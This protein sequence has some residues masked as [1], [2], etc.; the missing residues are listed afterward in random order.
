MTS[1]RRSRWRALWILP[2]VALGIAA[3]VFMASGRQPPARSETV[4]TAYP[5]RTI[6]VESVEL[7]PQASGY[8]EVQPAKV[9]AAVAQVAGRV[10]ETHA[11]L[12]N[13]EIVPA[14]TLLF[15][16]DPV[17]YELQ[18]AQA[19]AELAE[20]DVQETN[21]RASLAI[22]QRNLRLAEREQARLDKLRSNGTASQ[23]DVDT[24]ERATLNARTS[25]Q[26]TENTLA[27]LPT[28]RRLLEA[29]VAQAERDLANTAVAAPFN[30]RVADLAVERDQYVGVGQTLFKGD[31]V[32]SVEIVAQV[33]MTSLRNLFIGRDRET[34]SLDDLQSHLADFTGFRPLVRMNLGG[35]TAEWEAGFVR[36][37]DQVDPRTRSIGVVV[38]V[39][40]PLG[41]V[42]PGRRPPL[43]KG[44]F[45]DVVIRGRPQPDRVVLPRSALRNGAVYLVDENQRLQTRPL[46]LLFNQ[47]DLSVVADGLRAGDRLVVTDPVPAVAG[48][49]L[50]P[51]DDEALQTWLGDALRKLQ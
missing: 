15:R 16:I 5:V 12:R 34:L 1:T 37:S 42:I 3:I 46:Q 38:R 35:V 14:G 26:N 30:L 29:K 9:W 49:P 28:Q 21:A 17:D 25:V 31:A 39:D 22:D 6:T 13:G 36:F 47:G 32:D 10:I 33:A 44:M 50:I 27:L 8:G 43:S 20:L 11:R 4:E 40:D 51:R 19:Q 2:P 48:M 7:V 23:S 18:L 41:K 24:A 45:V